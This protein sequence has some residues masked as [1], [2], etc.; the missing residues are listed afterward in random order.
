[1][2]MFLIVNGIHRYGYRSMRV[3]EYNSSKEIG[4]QSLQELTNSKPM[5][6]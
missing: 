3:V 5:S 6:F 2:K 4:L 1:M